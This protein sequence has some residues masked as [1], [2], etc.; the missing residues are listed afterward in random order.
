MQKSVQCQVSEQ[1]RIYPCPNP[2][3]TLTFC[4]FTVNGLEEGQARNCSDTDIDQKKYLEE[5]KEA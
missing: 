2:T 5:T 3:L 4:Q 1:L